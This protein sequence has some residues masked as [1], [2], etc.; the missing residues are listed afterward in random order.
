MRRYSQTLSVLRF[1]L[2][3]RRG[4]T[5]FDKLR[6]RA[7]RG[8]LAEVFTRKSGGSAIAVEAFMINAG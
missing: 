8:E 3:E 5:A 4:S 7:C 6:P 1:T 2:H